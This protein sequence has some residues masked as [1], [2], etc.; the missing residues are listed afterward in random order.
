MKIF[1]IGMPGCGKSVLGKGLSKSINLP[2]IDL[3]AELEKQENLKVSEIFKS[4][5]QDYFRD[6]EAVALRS[7]STEAE[8][9]MATGG[10]TPCFH[11][12]MEFINETGTS[13]FLNTPVHVIADRLNLHEKQVRPLLEEIPHGQLVQNLEEILR[14]RKQYYEQAHFTI[15]G[16]TA[17]VWD[18]LQLLP[19]F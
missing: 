13:I 16:A 19:K 2:F 12:N 10:G 1:L 3:D 8:F 5:G 18:V 6:I 14:R 9:V 4:K 7:R 11:N 15:A 17:T